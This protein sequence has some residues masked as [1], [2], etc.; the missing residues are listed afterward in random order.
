[1]TPNEVEAAARAVREM[2]Q[3]DETLTAIADFNVVS[4]TLSRGDGC[5]G[6]ISDIVLSKGQSGTGTVN[7]IGYPDDLR[8]AMTAAFHQ[9]AEQKL[10][11]ATIA[12]RAAGVQID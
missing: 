2:K 7:S 12:A 9:W 10:A 11:N 6:R 5:G 1:M 3:A 4:I 8:A